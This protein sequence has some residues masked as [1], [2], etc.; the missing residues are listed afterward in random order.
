M[1]KF[2]NSVDNFD[3]RHQI[4]LV[5]KEI[6]LLTTLIRK[7]IVWVVLIHFFVF[8]GV[9]GFFKSLK[10]EFIAERT[11]II[12]N[13][14]ASSLG[15]LSG[16]SSVFGL[17]KAGEGNDKYAELLDSP[18]FIVKVLLE[19]NPEQPGSIILNQYIQEYDLREKWAHSSD[20]LLNFISKVDITKQVTN[21]ND[22]F[23]RNLV[24]KIVADQLLKAKDYTYRYDKK[25]GLFSIAY[26][27]NH[28][29]FSLAFTNAA[30]S[31]F[32]NMIYNDLYEQSNENLSITKLKLDSI[33]RELQKTTYSYANKS[34]RTLGL[35]SQEDN[36]PKNESLMKM[37]SLVAIYGEALKQYETFKFVN[38]SEKVNFLVIT[39]PLLPLL[40]IKSNWKLYVLITQMVTFIV[41]LGFYR[42][43]YYFV[44]SENAA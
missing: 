41:L 29:D 21:K 35:I 42:L 26:K 33:Y 27:C 17:G 2:D 5:M 22:Q 24:A 20:S 43:R 23:K 36:V 8:V 9:F 25:T 28:A 16:L 10:P 4:S 18:N 13:S 32:K 34:D 11:F 30:F 14:S 3:L 15:G 40:P 1:D 12:E 6:R 38:Q 44:Q 19:P 39:E 7:Y 31:Q 37:N